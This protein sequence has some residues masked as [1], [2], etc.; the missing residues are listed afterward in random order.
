MM[1]VTLVLV[2]L[3]GLVGRGAALT[4]REPPGDGEWLRC[5]LDKRLTRRLLRL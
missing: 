3:V 2:T 1:K 4:E 5:E